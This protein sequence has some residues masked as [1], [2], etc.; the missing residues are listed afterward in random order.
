M[1]NLAKRFSSASFLLDF[2][3]V[4]KIQALLVFGVGCVVGKTKCA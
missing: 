1:T 2:S 3:S 4:G